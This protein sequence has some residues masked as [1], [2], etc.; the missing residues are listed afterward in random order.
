MPFPKVFADP[1][2]SLNPD[3]ASSVA[4]PRTMDI[5]VLVN[6]PDG[7][8]TEL[9]KF[10]NCDGFAMAGAIAGTS[11]DPD[12]SENR[13]VIFFQMSLGESGLFQIISL[14]EAEEIRD[15]LG[16]LIDGLK[17]QS[18]DDFIMNSG[19]EEVEQI[20]TEEEEE[21]DA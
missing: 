18:Y 10:M 19:K 11:E 9:R 7:I 16:K 13:N 20:G 6:T 14:D 15:K 3:R 4:A 2:A 1:E 8:R 5:P 12:E 17:N 21:E